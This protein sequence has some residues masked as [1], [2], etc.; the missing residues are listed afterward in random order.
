MVEVFKLNSIEEGIDEQQRA[1]WEAAKAQRTFVE[2]TI[3]QR[4]FFFSSRRRHTRFKCDW[5][6]DVCS[7]DLF[8]GSI[9]LRVFRYSTPARASDAKSLVVAVAKLPVDLATPRSSTRKTAIP[10]RVR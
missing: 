5:S 3:L 2:G 6:S 10:R 9:S 7:S 1:K 4:D 8:L